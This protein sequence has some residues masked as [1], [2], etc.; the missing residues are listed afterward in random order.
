[1]ELLKKLHDYLH[2]VREA[3]K[4]RKNHLMNETVYVDE[5]VIGTRENG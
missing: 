3:M 1:L 2:K 5:F 4:S